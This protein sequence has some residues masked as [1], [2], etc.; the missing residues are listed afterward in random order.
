MK[1]KPKVFWSYAKSRLKTREQISTLTK[2]DG[3]VAATPQDKAETLNNFFASVFTVESLTN[4]PPA[5]VLTVD[6]VVYSII[7]S[8]ELVRDKLLALKP[9]KSPG[10]DKWHL[11]P[12]IDSSSYYYYR[13][14][15]R[16]GARQLEEGNNSSYIQ[17]RKEE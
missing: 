8:P 17:E 9:N 11:H 16:R 1:D 13:I 10:H 6:E 3:S 2:P 12:I 5:P 7:I 14:V 4:V 15:E